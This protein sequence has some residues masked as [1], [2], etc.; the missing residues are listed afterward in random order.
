MT[1]KQGKWKAFKEMCREEHPTSRD[2]MCTQAANLLRNK[3]TALDV[4]AD[5]LNIKNGKPGMIHPAVRQ[6][7]AEVV[8]GRQGTAAAFEAAYQLEQICYPLW[9]DERQSRIE[10]QL[11]E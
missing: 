7:Y 5:D 9:D 3:I 11:A 2:V 4:L 8:E 6:F 10:G 1:T